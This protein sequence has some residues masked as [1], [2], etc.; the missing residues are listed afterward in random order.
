MKRTM[1]YIKDMDMPVDCMECRCRI[2]C[3]YATSLVIGRPADC[4]LEE[5]KTG[6][7]I[8]RADAEGVL[9]DYINR[10]HMTP[11]ARLYSARS[12]LSALSAL[13]S[14]EAVSRDEEYEEMDGVIT[15]EKQSVKDVGEIK[16]IV[17]RSPNY[18]RYFYNESMPISAEAVPQS[19]QYKKG[20]ED[21]KRA[22]L[23]E[24]ARESE[25]MSKRNAALEVML[26]AQKAISAEAVHKPDYSY[27]ADMVRRLKESLSAEAEPTVI[28]CKT[29]L[30]AEDFEAVATRIRK[31]NRNVIVIP[32]ETE[33]VSA[34]A[35]QG[36]IPCSERLP[37]IGELVLITQ[38]RGDGDKT[39]ETAYLTSDGPNDL[40]WSIELFKSRETDEVLAW[41]P[42][43]KP[44]R[45]ESEVEE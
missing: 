3:I 8:R 36:W 4:P 21:A 18:T 33:V 5:A 24:Y 30:N 25:N 31:E 20:F 12:A 23:L 44:Y 22:F 9:E 41:M 16:H 1:I 15:I 32:C 39:V 27:E 29:L 43:P 26:N 13:P 14:V 34:E 45:E 40:Y 35:V 38:N 11:M 42:L 7:L 17:I 28:R 6:D 19:E 37:D 2:G 10:E